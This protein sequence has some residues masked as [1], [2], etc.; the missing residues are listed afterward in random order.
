MLGVPLERTEQASR[1]NLKDLKK[2]NLSV[3][4]KRLKQLNPKLKQMPKTKQEAI[5]KYEL[6][7]QAK[8]KADKGGHADFL[9]TREPTERPYRPMHPSDRYACSSSDHSSVQPRQTERR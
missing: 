5:K 8:T 7:D 4:L 2:A 1:L 9:R 6:A 3:I